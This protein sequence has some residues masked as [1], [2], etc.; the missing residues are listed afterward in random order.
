MV[1]DMTPCILSAKIKNIY[2]NHKSNNKK[3]IESGDNLEIKK[4]FINF[5]KWKNINLI[6]NMTVF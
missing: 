2:K 3:E 1:I 4:A 6:I 5:E